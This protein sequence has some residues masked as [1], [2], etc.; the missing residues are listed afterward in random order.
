MI[1]TS[2]LSV[3]HLPSR[4]T[5]SSPWTSLGETEFDGGLGEEVGLAR[6][7]SAPGD[8]TGFVDAICIAICPPKVPRSVTVYRG[9]C[10]WAIASAASRP[11]VAIEINWVA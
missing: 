3:T 10:D 1:A 7:R 6:G 8:L 9:A 11:L 2:A 4:S 5:A